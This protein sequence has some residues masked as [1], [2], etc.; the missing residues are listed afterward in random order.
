MPKK[1]IIRAVDLFAGAGGA[2]TGLVRAC[3]E[4]G[5]ELDLLAINHWPVAVDTHSVNHPNVVH[6]CESIAAVDPLQK[7]FVDK[8]T[9]KVFKNTGRL[10]ILLAG[11]ECTHFSTARGGRPV[12][13]QSRASAW[14][15]LKWAQELY[16]DVLLIENVPEWEMWGP[17]GANFK[18]LK[19]KKGETFQ[20]YLQAIRS[21]GYSRVEFRKLNSANYGDAT[22][23]N[24]LFLFAMRN[25][26]SIPWPSQSHAKRAFL[27]GAGPVAEWTTARDKVID[28][29]VKGKNIFERPKPLRPATMLRIIAG[30]E[31]F[32]GPRLKPF[33][34]QLRI[35]C[36]RAYAAEEIWNYSELIAWALP[37]SPGMAVLLCFFLMCRVARMA[38]MFLREQALESAVGTALEPFLIVLR[39][40]VTAMSVNKPLSTVVGAGKHHG[41]V[42]ATLV[43]MEHGGRELDPEQPLPTVTTAKGGAFGVAE[44]CLVHTTHD[45]DRKPH[46][47]DGPVP[48]ITGAHRG[49][50]GVAEAFVLQQ[51]SGG[52]PRSVQDPLPTVAT[53]GAISL[54]APELQ[55]ANGNDAVIVD[56]GFGEGEGSTTRRGLGA[57]SPD[58]PLGVVPGSNRFAIAEPVLIPFYSE[59]E[60]QE[61]R[62]HSVD[63]PV[64]TIPATG[65]GKFA[66][67]EP[68]IVPQSRF[69]DEE[70]R[71]DSVDQPLRTITGTGGRCFG[72]A[73]PSLIKYYGTATGAQSVD[74]P[75]DTLTAKERHALVEPIIIEAGG[76]TGQGRNANSVDEPLT[77]V[78]TE[79]HKALVEP[80]ILS[81]GGPEVGARPVSQPLNTVL[82]RDHMAL[83]ETF[84]SPQR[85]NS[86]PHSVDEPL[87]TL[88]G[89]NHMAVIDPFVIANNTNN[90]AKSVDEP[91]PTVTGANRLGFVD[92][93]I[94]KASNGSMVK[95]KGPRIEA[96]V[97]DGFV[98]VILFRMLRSRELARAMSFPDDY[99]FTGTQEN[100]VKQIG[101]AWAGELAKAL[102]KA[103]LQSIVKTPKPR[104]QEKAA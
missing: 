93:Q 104:R 103:A 43:A 73:E 95:F 14:H 12:N 67:A 50:L 81:A 70:P 89:S 62:S 55:K 79:N 53:G 19:S 27:T 24:R 3:R 86:A 68:F 21:L 10:D 88:T 44:A 90:I 42:D 25:S 1:R 32:G 98:L 59:G 36:T 34:A 18:P 69:D 76:P 47:V 80:L 29:T 26:S 31:K 82:T 16:I 65:N 64:P 94:V 35:N 40:N 28:W 57:Y 15:I 6:L 77:T 48:T 60:G 2:S 41:L 23:R 83:A 30:L 56:A 39:N 61:P 66:V 38:D 78:L 101:N 5:L 74:E 97:I 84:I 96:P 75:L 45:G 100:V 51:Q 58:Q 7:E 4:L 91:V 46:A 22:T 33:L 102:C 11:P 13:P 8:R 87:P 54:V 37:N 17:C 49:E 63:E 85:S 9:G 52:A 20:A 92:T 72:L 99:E 71:I